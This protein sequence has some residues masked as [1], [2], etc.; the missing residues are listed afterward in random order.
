MDSFPKKASYDYLIV[1]LE[2]CLWC[3]TIKL[4]YYKAKSHNF[5]GTERL[6]IER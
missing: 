4:G 5:N 3:K 2:F 6:W 1:L